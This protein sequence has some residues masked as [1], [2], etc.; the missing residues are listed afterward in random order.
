VFPGAAEVCDERDN[1]C[2]GTTD[3]D[4][5][6]ALQWFADADDDGFGDAASVTVACDAPD[7]TIDDATDCDDSSSAVFPGAAEVCDERDNDCDGTTDEDVTAIYYADADGDGF[8]SATDT[9]TQCERPD[10]YT[11]DAT[12]CDDDDA[13]A[14]PGAEEVCGDGIDNDCSGAAD[15][16]CDGSVTETFCSTG[17]GSTV[18]SDGTPSVAVDAVHS[19]WISEIAGATWI[20]DEAEESDPERTQTH[21]F[22][23]E[24]SLPEN[25][26][27][28]RALLEISADNTWQARFNGELIAADYTG[29]TFRW[30]ST[31]WVPAAGG[32]NRLE[33]AVTNT[34]VPGATA[35]RNPGG[36][37]YCVTV[38]YTEEACEESLWYA[39]VDGD[40]IGDEFDTISSCV[41]PSGHVSQAGDCDDEDPD[42]S[43]WAAEV[44]DDI[45]NDCSGWVDDIDQDGSG[46]DDC[47]EVA[48]VISD[49]DGDYTAGQRLLERAEVLIDDLGL[50]MVVIDAESL[51]DLT[52]YSA[53]V[54]HGD[55]SSSSTDLDIIDALE[56]AEDAGV[57]LVLLGDALA[58]SA[59]VLAENGEYGLMDLLWLDTVDC[60]RT[61]GGVFPTDNEHA[62]SDGISRLHY[63][64]RISTV[65]TAGAGESVLMAA[66]EDPLVWAAEE[67][68]QRTVAMLMSIH[69]TTSQPLSDS[70]GQEEIDALFQNALWWAMHR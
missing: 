32:D 62:V 52:L 47:D 70:D 22:V 44:C 37:L 56:D 1:D 42:V 36:L 12:D 25:I 39:D 38:T 20:W 34:G 13:A 16:V 10:G 63:R 28:E 40:G 7:G 15:E 51:D 65:A 59:A 14:W 60:T 2:D 41:Q 31:W 29:G 43:P 21:T 69:G 8:G 4:A 57:G 9:L 53:V 11:D 55:G 58:S 5:S 18:L 23:R 6:D 49:N 61:G 46:V 19:G 3:E 35:E 48:V 17:D 50:S 27:V 54:Y 24:F 68:G 66:G 64:G 26:K 45:D 30:S 33:V 67:D